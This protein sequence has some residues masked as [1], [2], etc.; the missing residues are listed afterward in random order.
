MPNDQ[1]TEKGNMPCLPLISI[2]DPH[3]FIST[4][5]KN[6]FLNNLQSNAIIFRLLMVPS[7]R[8]NLIHNII[9]I[10]NRIL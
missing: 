4:T 3:T 1:E 7:K 8:P 2:F 6:S 10:S 9:I 5:T